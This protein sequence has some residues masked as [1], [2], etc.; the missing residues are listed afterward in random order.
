MSLSS[1]LARDNAEGLA[2]RKQKY[3]F[4]AERLE[5]EERQGEGGSNSMITSSRHALSQDR[6]PAKAGISAVTQSQGSVTPKALTLSASLLVCALIFI[7]GV[8]W[9][10]RSNHNYTNREVA[11]LALNATPES[12]SPATLESK[13]AATVSLQKPPA[14]RVNWERV[15]GYAALHSVYGLDF[16]EKKDYDHAI[17]EYSEA[18]RLDPNNDF[19]NASVYYYRGLAYRYK[20]E[21]D[22]A[23]RDFNR[24][25]LLNPVRANAYYYRGIAYYHKE[26]YDNAIRDFNEAIFLD[27]SDPTAYYYRGVV[28]RE[29]GK[30][31][32]AQADFDQSRQLGYQPE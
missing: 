2:G 3:P 16:Y 26:E 28:Y 15:F 25:I 21:Y 12:A 29:Q 23:I 18:I 31:A 30:D 1:D 9:L 8:I 5:A 10:A 20:S 19:A 24:A 13:P 17:S 27:P 14:P 22:Q 7:V 6:S 11:L 4:D 32:E